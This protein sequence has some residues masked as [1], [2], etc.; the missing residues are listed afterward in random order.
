EYFVSQIR[1]HRTIAAAALISLVILLAGLGYPLMKWIGKRAVASKVLKTIMLTTTCNVYEAAISPDGKYLAYFTWEGGLQIR[2]LA[3]N[4]DTQV[5]HPG[6]RPFGNPFFA[7]DGKYLYYQ[8]GTGTDY[9]LTSIAF[10][11]YRI[12]VWG[13]PAEKIVDHIPLN[14]A[15]S[16]DGE[17]LAFVRS[18]LNTGLGNL[19]IANADGTE[20]RSIIA[21]HD[22]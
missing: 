16:P 20:E 19:V 9:T 22:P 12:P 11:L 7:A 14:T 17:K 6:G 5:V 10:A 4:E 13:G 21:P 3:T 1:E 15:L 2:E 8:Q 18:D